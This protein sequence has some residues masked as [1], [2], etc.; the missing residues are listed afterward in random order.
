[1]V[2]DGAATALPFIPAGAGSTLKAARYGDY[3]KLMKTCCFVAGTKILTKDGYKNIE[4]IKLGEFV[5]AKH[6]ETGEQAYKPVTQLFKKNRIVHELTVD[7]EDGTQKI[8]ETT[9]DHP[10]FVAGKGFVDAVDQVPSD[11]IETDGHGLAVIESVVNTEQLSV[12]YNFE[13]ADFHTYYA[14]EKNLLVHNCD[15]SAR[16]QEIRCSG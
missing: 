4:D 2:I 6:P 12:T 5:L 13:V 14:T 16:H 11:K 1:V 3:A 7:F 15:I 9:D 10:F 8:L